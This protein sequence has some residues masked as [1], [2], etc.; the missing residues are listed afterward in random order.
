M[1]SNWLHQFQWPNLQA[2]IIYWKKKIYYLIGSFY[3][4]TKYFSIH[5]RQ[6]CHFFFLFQVPKTDRILFFI[7]NQSL[8]RSSRYGDW[9]FSIAVHILS[10]LWEHS[11]LKLILNTIR[12]SSKKL[13]HKYFRTFCLYYKRGYLCFIGFQGLYMF[14]LKK[15]KI[16]TIVYIYIHRSERN[17]IYSY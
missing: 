6:L 8:L 2:L 17:A 10:L 16:H 1:E 7:R 12:I 9:V 3:S 5:L 13:I 4:V 14:F 15:K 11:R